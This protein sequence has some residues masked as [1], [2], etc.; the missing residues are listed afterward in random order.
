LGQQRKLV[1]AFAE[2]PEA[3]N[4]SS[5]SEVKVRLKLLVLQGN[6]GIVN[7]GGKQPDACIKR[8]RESRLK[9]ARQR[10]DLTDQ[11]RCTIGKRQPGPAYPAIGRI[12]AP[13]AILL[14]VAAKHFALQDLSR[15]SFTIKWN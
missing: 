3:Q 7:R 6:F 5:Q 2:G 11:H 10:K 9:I 8:R 13:A 15:Q 4:Q 12:A 1:T 14:P